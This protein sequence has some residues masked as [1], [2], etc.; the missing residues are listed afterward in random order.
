M[1][2]NVTNQVAFLR[3]TREF[4]EEIHQLCTEVNKSYLDIANVVNA[5]TIGLFPTNR[6]A[7]TGESWFFSTRRQQ[8]QRQIYPISDYSSITHNLNFQSISTFTVIRAIG[9]DG[10]IYFPIPYINGANSV[11]IHVTST[12]VVFDVTGAPPVLTN[13][14]IL[15]EWLLHP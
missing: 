1:S 13:G 6:P 12:Q 7:I 4:P 11:G 5:R 10:T 2:A 15:L 9:Y 3:T 14:F 8:T